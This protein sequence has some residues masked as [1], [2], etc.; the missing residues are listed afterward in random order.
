M[1]QMSSGWEDVV[2]VDEKYCS[3]TD[4]SARNMMKYLTLAHYSTTIYICSRLHQS[5]RLH[6]TQHASTDTAARSEPALQHSI[7]NLCLS[8]MPPCIPGH[9]PSTSTSSRSRAGHFAISSPT[10]TLP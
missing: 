1:G 5:P 4:E 7:D 6:K 10:T 8:T 9:H 3:S 2:V